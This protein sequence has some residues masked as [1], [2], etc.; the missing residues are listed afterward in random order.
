MPPERGGNGN[1]AVSAAASPRSGGVF[2]ESS[3]R[4]KAP[5][6][7]EYILNEDWPRRADGNGDT[8][9]AVK[10]EAAGESVVAIKVA[11]GALKEAM[12]VAPGGGRR[13]SSQAWDQEVRL[14]RRLAL[15]GKRS[16]SS[17][18]QNQEDKE[19]GG[20]TTPTTRPAASY[21]VEFGTE[22]GGL[23]S[24]PSIRLLVT[25]PVCW[26]SL[27]A[28]IKGVERG[29]MEAYT[30]NQA[31]RWCWEITRGLS[32]LHA[33]DIGYREFSLRHVLLTQP[34]GE[35]RLGDFDALLSEKESAESDSR[36]GLWDLGR[37]LHMT[38]TCST[39]REDDKAYFQVG[40]RDSDATLMLGKAKTSLF[41]PLSA[42]PR[43]CLAA[44]PVPVRPIVGGL[45]AKPAKALPLGL[46][47]DYLSELVG[48]ALGRRGTLR[49][50]EEKWWWLVRQL[51]E[52]DT[53][54]GGGGGGGGGK[55]EGKASG[56]PNR[57]EA[58][59]ELAEACLELGG[60]WE[61]RG[62]WYKA[63]ELYRDAIVLVSDETSAKGKLVAEAWGRIA[64]IYQGQG[65]HAAAKEV[66]L[67]L[68]Q[69]Y[70]AEFAAC[71]LRAG[72]P[73]EM[74]VWRNAIT[75]QMQVEAGERLSNVRVRLAASLR[76]L[77]G[78]KE[79]MA[80]LNTARHELQ[81][82]NAADGLGM[83]R[84]NTGKAALYSQRKEHVRALEMY[85]DA[86][87]CR[88]KAVPRD[89]PELASL[90]VCMAE[91]YAEKG[92]TDVALTMLIQAYKRMKEATP[93]SVSPSTS[94]SP[95]SPSSGLLSYSAAAGGG[96][97]GGDLLIMAGTLERIGKLFIHKGQLDDALMC[98]K[99]AH[100]RKA[101][102]LARAHPAVASSLAAMA[103]VHEKKGDF[104]SAATMHARALEVR[105]AVLPPTSPNI[106]ASLFGLG[107]AHQRLRASKTALLAYEEAVAIRR[108]HGGASLALGDVLVN[109]SRP[110]KSL[111]QDA[112]AIAKLQE[113][114]EVY[115]LAGLGP[116]DIR[117]CTVNENLKVLGA[118]MHNRGGAGGQHPRFSAPRPLPDR[119]GLLAH[120]AASTNDLDGLAQGKG[121]PLS[122]KSK[123]F[124]PVS[125]AKGKGE[126]S[127]AVG[128]SQQCSI[129]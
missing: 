88:R 75:R 77:G 74:E 87:E 50:L 80:Q 52:H 117:M 69:L 7:A 113:A 82:A 111:G 70:E 24:M 101:T 84:V 116:E 37:V 59:V 94:P 3:I 38:L 122:A 49:A 4:F 119:E 53:T 16:S 26:K 40:R 56:G 121:Q 15:L 100:E 34:D 36:Q 115:H 109:M 58:S 27:D 22:F 35:V 19:G 98:Y 86:L 10:R 44:L 124:P 61:E 45:L 62:K 90:L 54:V 110:L 31:L 39:D 51:E 123:S 71:Q 29:Y 102:A 118:L 114:R 107:N 57:R 55:A 95:R 33:A 66:L 127:R 12:A 13:E 17:S 125:P 64:D 42:S 85:E 91:V 106:A 97:K 23:K 6:G 47:L 72:T 28:R 30:P 2:G 32:T 1:D 65:D 43:P 105:R 128:Q 103:A 48:E 68:V 67:R 99:A 21:T 46:A 78:T 89:D 92:D 18:S 126:R 129:Q 63:V 112:E 96:G 14:L 93:A 60:A 25:T 9:R 41:Q 108:T 73:Q 5:N 79:A 20:A 104:R 8:Y 83:V 81:Q 120:H 11:K 76:E